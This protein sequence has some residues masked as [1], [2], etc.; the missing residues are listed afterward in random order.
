MF[1]RFN[2]ELKGSPVPSTW[3]MELEDLLN[4]TYE[5][6]LKLFEKRIKVFGELHPKEIAMAFS[7]MSRATDCTDA[8]TLMVSGDLNEK[9]DPKKTLDHILNSS[10]EFFD[11]IFNDQ[12]Q[13]EFQ[14]NWVKTDLKKGN[15]F[16]KITR[17]NVE[18][19]LLANKLLE[20]DN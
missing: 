7:I 13:D 9:D 17:E 6:Q 2:E 15:F 10:S 1:S 14:P 20:G 12:G 4:S 5:G 3:I 8:I 19:T 11:L 18:L 16:F